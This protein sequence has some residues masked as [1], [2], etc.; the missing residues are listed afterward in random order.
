[1]EDRQDIVK[2]FELRALKQIKEMRT[3]HTKSGKVKHKKGAARV[4]SAKVKKNV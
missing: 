4:R 3:T 1:M 2:Q